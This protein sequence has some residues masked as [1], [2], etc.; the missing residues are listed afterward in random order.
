MLLREFMTVRWPGV[1]TSMTPCSARYAVLLVM[2]LGLAL[3][4]IAPRNALA[5]EATNGSANAA[6]SGAASHGRFIG[7]MPTIY[8][9]W[10]KNSFLDFREDIDEAAAGGKRVII[11]FHQDG[12][13]YCN[14]LVERNLTQRDIE[15]LLREKFAVVA[16]N[17][18]GDREVVSVSGQSF[19]EKEFAAALQVQF[20]PTLLFFN[21]SA[22]LALRLNG[23]LPPA[24]FKRAL[25]Y[26]AGRHEK[27]IS[28]REYVAAHAPPPVTSDAPTPTSAFTETPERAADKPTV[29]LF[30]QRDCPNCQTLHERVLA[31]PQSAELLTQFNRQRIDMWADTPIVTPT[32]QAT[33]ARAYADALGIDYAPSLVLFDASGREVIR[34]SAYFKRFH[35]QGILDYVASGAYRNEPSFQRYLN[36][37]AEALRAQG[38]DVDIW[39]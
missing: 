30:E 7:A 34:T 19:T 37:R 32:G 38:H 8:P 21:E 28:Y 31:L 36:A 17:M 16:L 1:N 6:A 35:T 9:D 22:E 27:Q 20:T 18:W 25:E 11:L 39:D 10:F 13:P 2:L 15:Q 5:S 23:Y 24:D 33:T 14:A 3:A 4:V 29:V 12:C 26:V